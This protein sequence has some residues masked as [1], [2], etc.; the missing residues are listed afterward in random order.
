MENFISKSAM[1]KQ[2]EKRN[3]L[4]DGIFLYGQTPT[5][6]AGE[7]KYK[8]PPPPG[9]EDI[10]PVEADLIRKYQKQD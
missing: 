8:Y 1:I 4:V 9:K 7:W 5:E 6:Y 2:L 10:T 3:I